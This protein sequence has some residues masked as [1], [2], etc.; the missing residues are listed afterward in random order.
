M[1]A[2][3]RRWLLRAT[4]AALALHMVLLRE[5]LAAGRIE[6][7]VYRVRGE[8]WVNDAP[9]QPGM[10]V[11]AG[12]SVRTGTGSE[13]VY[14]IARDAMLVRADA[15]IELDGARGALVETG[16]RIV[17]GAVLSVFA[18]GEQRRIRTH[19][20]TIGIRGT[21]IYVE[22]QAERTYVCTCY[23]V[24]DIV[25]VDDPAQGET[26]R[27]HHHDQPRYVMAQG[28][29]QMIVHAPVINHGDAELI[30]LESLVGR[31]PPFVTSG[32][33]PGSY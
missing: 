20:A 27:T 16:L 7:G 2:D 21:G 32:Y 8:A 33:R 5:A 12:D 22:S 9:A 30:L 14:V 6:E 4:G 24:A 13:V 15:Q 3:R 28:A 29:P 17:S 18:S 31:K 10:A 25:P 23:G 11:R 26:V 19:T 1:R